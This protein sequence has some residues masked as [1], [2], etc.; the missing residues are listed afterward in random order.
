MKLGGPPTTW[1]HITPG[2]IVLERDG[3]PAV[4]YSSR[5]SLDD[6]MDDIMTHYGAMM[7]FMIWEKFEGWMDDLETPRP[8]I[9]GDVWFA[10]CSICEEPS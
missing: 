9:R 7:D 6:A 8:P 5:L 10:K 3:A 4:A 1:V 2:T